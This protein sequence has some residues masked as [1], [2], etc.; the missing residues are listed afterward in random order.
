MAETVVLHIGT[1]K[2]GS[3]SLQQLLLDQRDGLLAEAGVAYPTGLVIPASHAELPLLAI[4]PDR[5]W[6]ARLRFP[7]TQDPR[8]LAAAAAH[9][10]DV[11]D[12]SPYPV[13]VFSHEDLSYLRHDDELAALRSLLGERRVRV[14]VFLRDP[15][16][17]LRSY[18]AQLEATGFP[19]SADPASFAFVEEGSWLVDHDALLGAY[20]R[21]FGV[22]N[23]EVLDYDEAVRRD[24][25]VIPAFTDQLGIVRS[26]L[27]DLDPYFL[28]RSGGHLRPNPEQVAAI[29]R[30]LAE[31]TR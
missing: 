11:L 3:T 23:V 20:R 6:P 26:S 17:F 31:Q 4:R 22:E 29:R 18:R 19:P 25:S 21:G 5:T 16:A 14:V 9:V 7:E 13:T 27:P 15:A 1:H 30:R 2:T 8:W 24:G 12:H 28:N 10:R